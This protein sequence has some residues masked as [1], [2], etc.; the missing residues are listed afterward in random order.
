MA[1]VAIVHTGHC[2]LLAHVPIC[3]NIVDTCQWDQAAWTWTGPKILN[4]G[5]E[6]PG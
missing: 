6:D 2:I 1:M 3:A 5:N 4:A